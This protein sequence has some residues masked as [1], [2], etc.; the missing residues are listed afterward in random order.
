M[1][2]RRTDFN[3]SRRKL[4]ED[5]VRDIAR[6]KET[7]QVLADRFGVGIYAIRGVRCGRTYRDITGIERRK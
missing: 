5:Q 2:H 1:K 4:S 7:L 6:S 3:M